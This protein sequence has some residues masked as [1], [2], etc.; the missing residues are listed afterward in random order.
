M[1]NTTY[2]QYNVPKFL[3]G[4]G[5]KFLKEGMNVIVAFESEEPIMA[6]L[7]QN[8]ELEITYTEPAVKAILQQMHKNM[9]LLKLELKYVYPCLLTKAT[10]L[11]LIPEQGIT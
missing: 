7:P 3:F 11:K 5:I 10:K 1:D 4:D 8:V 2:E 9:R 6:Q